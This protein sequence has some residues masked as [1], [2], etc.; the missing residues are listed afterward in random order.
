MGEE[1]LGIER[2]NVQVA[3]SQRDL[4]FSVWEAAERGGRV[5]AV[6]TSQAGGAAEREGRSGCRWTRALV[7][8]GT[9]WR[10]IDL[11]ESSSR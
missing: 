5:G 3:A 2:N 8:T 6:S 7:H 11:G 9:S 10:C 1:E 4:G